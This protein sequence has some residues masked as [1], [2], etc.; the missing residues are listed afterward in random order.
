MDYWKKQIVEKVMD[1]E[2]FEGSYFHTELCE[3]CLPNTG[4]LTDTGWHRPL[5]IGLLLWESRLLSQMKLQGV[6]T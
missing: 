6:S 5:W 3:L 1:K 4:I 2:N